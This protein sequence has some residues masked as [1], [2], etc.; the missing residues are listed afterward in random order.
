MVHVSKYVL[1]AR[2]KNRKIK[3]RTFSV[4]TACRLGQI[5]SLESLSATEVFALDL[6]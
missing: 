2:L 6:M 3:T 5:Q 4:K 1:F